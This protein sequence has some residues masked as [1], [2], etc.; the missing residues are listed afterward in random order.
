MESTGSCWSRVKSSSSPSFFHLPLLCIPRVSLLNCLLLS[1]YTRTDFFC[2]FAH[3]L[4]LFSLFANY[5]PFFNQNLLNNPRYSFS[6]KYA[7]RRKTIYNFR[8]LVSNIHA[9]YICQDASAYVFNQTLVRHTICNTAQLIK[10]V[11]TSIS[12]QVFCNASGN[13]MTI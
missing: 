9:W 2:I 12:K 6:H 7:Y 8:C 4:F 10:T 1:A 3:S 13:W 11:V 5:L